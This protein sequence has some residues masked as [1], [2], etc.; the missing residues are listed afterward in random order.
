MEQARLVGDEFLLVS[1]KTFVDEVTKDD[2][3]RFHKALR[4]RGAAPRTIRISTR[5]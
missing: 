3:Y 4:E 5:G 1:R 2:V